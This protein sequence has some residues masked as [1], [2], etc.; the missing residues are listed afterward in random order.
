[1]QNTN[2]QNSLTIS[3]HLTDEGILFDVYDKDFRKITINYMDYLNSK[4]VASEYVNYENN[5]LKPTEDGK[6][7]VKHRMRRKFVNKDDFD[8]IDL[9]P[10]FR[11]S[12]TTRQIPFLKRIEEIKVYKLLENLKIYQ[13][14]NNNNM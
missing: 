12:E 3:T 8:L 9:H 5:T 1:M 13:H 7:E 6:I 11:L 2:L 10:D 14:Q 4:V